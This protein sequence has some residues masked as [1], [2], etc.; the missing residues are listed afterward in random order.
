[1]S[2]YRYLY[3][4]F[5]FVFS[6]SLAAS[7]G[8]H[9]IIID[10]Y[11]ESAVTFPVASQ[12]VSVSGHDLLVTN[13]YL[14]TVILN[15]SSVDSNKKPFQYQ[16]DQ[17]EFLIRQWNELYA[18]LL[19]EE[20]EIQK[21][22]RIATSAQFKAG[23][24]LRNAEAN[25]KIVEPDLLASLHDE[26]EKSVSTLRIAKLKQK[27]IRKL[28]EKSSK[29]NSNP[30]GI[31]EKKVNKT[32][33]DFNMFMARF[34]TAKKGNK[35]AEMPK[36]AIPPAKIKSHPAPRPPPAKENLIT[37]YDPAMVDKRPLQDNE[38]IY[39]SQPFGCV[40][41]TDTIDQGTGS[42][43]RALTPSV[44]FTHTDP[45]LRPYFR[46]KD[47]I[48]CIGRLSSIGPYVYLSIEFQIASSH[49]QSNFGSLQNGSLLRLKLMNGEYV[50]LYNLKTNTGRIDPYSGYTIFSGQ[51][52][53]S[54]KEMKKLKSTELDKMRVMW[55]T[56]FED[57]DVSHVDFLINQISCLMGKK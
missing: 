10:H 1:M 50:S 8:W 11:I 5:I 23:E 38:V 3:V 21:S 26:F 55:S 46:D 47:L 14:E 9:G 12:Q 32:R 57:Y 13:K 37:P 34:D 28:V 27:E 41:E 4:V 25:K 33:S 53:L 30:A 19:K 6:S 40:F 35:G 49:S 54:K 29:I 20:K 43:K 36:Q 24:Q 18:L 16:Q 52:G 42:V 15:T 48:T 39:T 22:F 7:A 31:T 17:Y 44:L 51:Y 56:G 45:D 2:S